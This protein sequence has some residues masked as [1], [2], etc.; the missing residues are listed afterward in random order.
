MPK[1]VRTTPRKQPRQARSRATVD[2]ILEATAQVLV[3][4]GYEG[5]STNRVAER[6]GVSVGSVYQ[7]FPNKEAL[8][9]ELVDRYAAE[10]LE[11]VLTR[12]VDLAEA[13]PEVVAPAIVRAMI[14]F[15]RRNPKLEG[16]LRHQIPRVGRL[17][18]YEARLDAVTRATEVYFQGHADRIEHD[19]L[20][21]TAFMAVRVVDA[22]T[23]AGVTSEPPIDA[24]VL[25]AHVTHLLLSYLLSAEDAEWTGTA[26]TR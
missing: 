17:R 3:K 11:M 4:E 10:A 12:L 18:S 14:D 6:A 16:V 22:A 24:D 26:S 8:V 21:V 1:A 25:A 2:A 9:G 19:D 5:T 13:P 7:Y 23:H 20:A 15:K